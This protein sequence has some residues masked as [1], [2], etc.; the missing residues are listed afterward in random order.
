[1][2]YSHGSKVIYKIRNI[3]WSLASIPFSAP[4]FL[5]LVGNH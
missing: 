5:L 3:K 1:M 2:K 4:Y